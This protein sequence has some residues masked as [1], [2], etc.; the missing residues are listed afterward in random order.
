MAS[1]SGSNFG[2]SKGKAFW[3]QHINH[4]LQSELSKMAYCKA[5]SLANS[6]FDRWCKKLYPPD[7][8]KIAAHDFMTLN[9]Q[10]DPLSDMASNPSLHVAATIE[11]QLHHSVVIKLNPPIDGEALFEVLKAVR[12]LP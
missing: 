9:L 11:I 8:G 7:S 2:P 10:R 5:H 6:S 3:D 4:W 1:A 12:Q